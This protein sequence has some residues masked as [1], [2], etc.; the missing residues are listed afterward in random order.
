MDAIR[1]L[2]QLMQ[3]PTERR[4]LFDAAQDGGGIGKASRVVGQFASVP[5]QT[6][7]GVV[8]FPHLIV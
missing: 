5:D 7:H 4:V 3:G 1:R 2:G 6:V 8:E